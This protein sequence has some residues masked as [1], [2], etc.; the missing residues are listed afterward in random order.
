MSAL[1]AV[2]LKRNCPFDDLRLQLR[3]DEINVFA[4]GGRMG[5]SS[6]FKHGKKRTQ[7]CLPLLALPCND[8]CAIIF[9]AH[10]ASLQGLR[11]PRRDALR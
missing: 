7:M 1:N 11:R 6:V 5:E 9:A 4:P 10:G 3:Q 8:Q 2:A